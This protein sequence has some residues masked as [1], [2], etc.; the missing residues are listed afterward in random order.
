MLKSEIA[1]ARLDVEYAQSV[2]KLE[3]EAVQHALQNTFE[4]K[5]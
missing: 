2:F 4:S 5:A 1:K 3:V